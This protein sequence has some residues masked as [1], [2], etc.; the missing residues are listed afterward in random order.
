M[1]LNWGILQINENKLAQAKEKINKSLKI[2]SLFFKS[3][4]D[5]F[6]D[7]LTAQGDIAQ[8]RGQNDI[9]K[10]KYQQALIIYKKHFSAKHWKIMET[11]RKMKFF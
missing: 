7:I 5:V 1:Y 6:A 11:E 4:H 2:N 8:K 3:N 9:A 10:T